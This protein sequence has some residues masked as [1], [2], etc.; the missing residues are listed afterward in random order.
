MQNR[1]SSSKTIKAFYGF[2]EKL[3]PFADKSV[4][5]QAAL[6][7]AWGATAIFGGYENPA[8]VDAIHEHGMQVY[9]EFGCFQGKRWWEEVPESRPTLA[10]GTLLDPIE[11]Y[12]GVNPSVPAVRE[13]LLEELATLLERHELDGVWLDFIRWPCRWESTTPRLLQTSFDETTLHRFATDCGLEYTQLQTWRDE[14]NTQHDY[15]NKWYHWRINQITSWVAQAR[16]LV[17]TIRPTATLGLFAIP[18][19]QQDF[20][21]AIQTVIGQDFVALAPY[22]DIFSPMTYHLMCGQPVSWIGA[23]AEEL[24]G[25][26]GK[27]VGPIIQSVDHPMAL[28]NDEYAEALASAVDGANAVI[29]FTLTG[30]IEGDRVDVTHKVWLGDDGT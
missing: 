11:W 29:I 18:W 12:H 15:A 16:T 1:A 22:I 26:T 5:Q 4:Q 8:F 9:A 23:V 24:T 27:Q 13:R 7:Q 28:S 3:P 19:R 25:L 30:V 10:D 6:L 14:P 2:D 21:G 20:G 17:D